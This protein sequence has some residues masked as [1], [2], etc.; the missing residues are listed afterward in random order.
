MLPI[1]IRKALGIRPFIVSL[2]FAQLS[3][4]KRVGRLSGLYEDLRTVYVV[5]SLG[6]AS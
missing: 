1:F 4:G 6:C 3:E 5:D 2:I